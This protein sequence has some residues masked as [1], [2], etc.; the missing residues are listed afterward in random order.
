MGIDGRHLLL[1]NLKNGM[2][3]F[4]IFTHKNVETQVWFLFE[5]FTWVTKNPNKLH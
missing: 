2:S 1:L 5:Y 3:H 4:S